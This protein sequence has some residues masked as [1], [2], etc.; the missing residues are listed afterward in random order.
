MEG[1]EWYAVGYILLHYCHV[2]IG[3]FLKI[4]GSYL[5]F[6]KIEVVILLV[7][8]TVLLKLLRIIPP[9]ISETDQLVEPPKNKVTMSGD[10]EH[11]TL[12]ETTSD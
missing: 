12:V 1:R 8:L 2:A 7:V 11:H 10:L 4:V 5:F 3:P 6:V 9:K